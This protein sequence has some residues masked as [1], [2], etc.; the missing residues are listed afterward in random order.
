MKPTLLQSFLR[1]GLRMTSEGNFILLSVS[2]VGQ[3]V[4][5]TLM[6]E[7]EGVRIFILPSLNLFQCLSLVLISPQLASIFRKGWKCGWDQRCNYKKEGSEGYHEGWE[8]RMESKRKRGNWLRLA[9]QLVAYTKLVY[10]TPATRMLR[11]WWRAIFGRW[12]ENFKSSRHPR[13]LASCPTRPI[14]EGT[15]YT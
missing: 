14:Y 3:L 12:I 15:V 9:I 1:F 13:L 4:Q 10:Y 7:R 6:N 11:E 2:L 8:K 5:A